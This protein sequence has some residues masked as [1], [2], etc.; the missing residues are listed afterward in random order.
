[1]AKQEMKEPIEPKK[2]EPVTADKPAKRRKNAFRRNPTMGISA[3]LLT[4]TSTAD[5]VPMIF[6]DDF[7]FAANEPWYAISQQRDDMLSANADCTMNDVSETGDTIGLSPQNGFERDVHM[8]LNH[9][10]ITWEL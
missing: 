9:G 7:D 2:Q 5:G 10:R 4:S 8:F 6:R 1:M 3:G